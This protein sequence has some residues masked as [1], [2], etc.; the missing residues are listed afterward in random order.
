MKNYKR[1]QAVMLP[2][3]EETDLFI[4]NKQ[5]FNYHK[6]Q[7]GDGVSAI[8]QHLHIISDDEIKEDAWCLVGV[9][10]HQKV[11]QCAELAYSQDG[12]TV[13]GYLFTDGTK[14]TASECK[15][16]IVTTDRKLTEDNRTYISGLMGKPNRL[17]QPSQQFIEKYIEFYNRGVVLSDVLVKYERIPWNLDEYGSLIEEEELRLKINPDNT[18]TIKELKETWNR[19]EV[20]NLMWQAYKHSNT[21]FEEE[22]GLRREFDKRIE[23]NL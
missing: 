11:K 4:V 8:N 14:H 2:T 17:P 18:I 5:L 9:Y 21:I 15:K 16:V 3:T 22:E 7:Q 10:P 12:K 13:N 23:E 20:I 19:K 6:H 1:A